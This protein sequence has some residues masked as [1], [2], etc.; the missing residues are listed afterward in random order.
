ME[1]AIISILALMLTVMLYLDRG[2][3]NDTRDLRAEMNTQF[4]AL[5]KEIADGN[6]SLR[7]EMNAG[8][9]RSDERL[10]AQ[11]AALRAEMADGNA[12]L[13][14]E[15]ADGNAALRAEIR[16]GFA[17]SDARVDQLTTAVIGL[18]ESLGQ[19]KGRTEVLVA[20]E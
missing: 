13:R 15:I 11:I 18:A 8:F 3:R 16:A 9:A 4:S 10:E 17:R 14:A 1:P 20:A 6:A 5:R 2:R 7:K 12:A 19:V